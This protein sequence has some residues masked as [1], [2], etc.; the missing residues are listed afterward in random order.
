MRIGST[1]CLFLGLV[2]ASCNK[3]QP[4]TTP[5][6]SPSPSAPVPIEAGWKEFTSEEDGFVVLFPTS[7]TTTSHDNRY[8]FGTVTIRAYTSNPRRN[9]IWRVATH[10]FPEAF[11]GRAKPEELLTQMRDGMAANVKGKAEGVKEVTLDGHPGQEFRVQA[12]DPLTSKPLI[13]KIRLYAVSN[14][15]Y[16]VG[17]TASADDGE[18]EAEAARYFASFRLIK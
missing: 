17:V 12:P 5:P 6:P 14:R 8:G 16:Q 7:P 11:A 10:N 4:P 3:S 1:L 9:V 18:L 2:T 13:N 15:I